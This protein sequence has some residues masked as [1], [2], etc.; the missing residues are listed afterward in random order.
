MY[1]SFILAWGGP[2]HAYLIKH[3]SANRLGMHAISSLNYW[4][5]HPYYH[6]LHPEDL[7]QQL[8]DKWSFKGRSGLECNAA[9]IR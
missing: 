1:K 4:S 8:P 5:D 9:A 7:A 6:T 2:A 3:Y